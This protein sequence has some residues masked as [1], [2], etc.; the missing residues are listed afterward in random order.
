MRWFLGI[1]I[2]VV[3]L[4]CSSQ[5]ERENVQKPQARIVSR[6]EALGELPCFRCHSYQKFTSRQKGAFSHALHRDTGYHCN[7]CHTFKAHSF[8]KING[9]LCKDC[10]N[11]K[12]FVYSSGGFPARFNHENHAKLGCKECHMGIFPMKKG[13]S[14]MTMDSIYEGRYC[15]ACHNGK[16]A[17]SSS[18]CGLC[19]EM[20]T[21]KKSVFY[22]VEGIGNVSFSHEFHTQM[23]A[24]DQCH[25]VIFNMRRSQNKITMDAL[26]SG[27]YCGACHNG[28]SAFPSSEC[29]KCHK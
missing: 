17:F 10:H 6:D 26:N 19:H 9:E 7:Q 14:R 16:K 4:S 23:F 2:L 18:E 27:K 29:A 22:K 25:P 15:G 11:L 13:I 20:K 12:I 28:Q 8:M 5:P 3:A 21:F 1:C 24:C